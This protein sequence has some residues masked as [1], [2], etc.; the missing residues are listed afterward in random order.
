[1]TEETN[2]MHDRFKQKLYGKRFE[3]KK[4]YTIPKKSLK[5][6]AQEKL[7]K[8]QRGDGDTELQKF[9]KS[10]MKRMVGEC[11]WC[12][13]RTETKNYSHAIF[14]ICHLLDKRDTKCPSV[15][16]HPLNWIELC[17]DH[18]QMFD[19]MNWEKREMLGFW[20]VIRDKLVMVWP[21]LAA[22]EQRH[23][24]DSVRKFMTDNNPFE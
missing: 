16:T 20:D 4:V 12:G 19:G 17:A 10:A 6:V 1:M 7:E 21:D 18:H 9:F 22:S 3:P 15:K 13:A 11:L 8:E 2:Y 14:S 24:P 23:F 5:R